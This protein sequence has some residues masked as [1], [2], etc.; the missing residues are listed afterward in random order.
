[1]LV[2]AVQSD[3]A[4]CLQY[5]TVLANKRMDAKYVDGIDFKQV[6]VYH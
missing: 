6:C 5:A 3:E 4:I 2:Y 1:L